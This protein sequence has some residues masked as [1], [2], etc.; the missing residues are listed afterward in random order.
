MKANSFTASSA[1]TTLSKA[2]KYPVY[3]VDVTQSLLTG[4]I[5]STTAPAL[6]PVVKIP[7]NARNTVPVHSVALP[8]PDN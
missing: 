4:S 8:T 2:P 7:L 5:L 1:K 6:F 3:R